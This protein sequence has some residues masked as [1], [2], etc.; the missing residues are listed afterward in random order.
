MAPQ[1]TL[2]YVFVAISLPPS[3]HFD[4]NSVYCDSHMEKWQ[5][6]LASSIVSPGELREYFDFDPAPLMEVVAKY[7][8]SI[9]RYYLGL[10]KEIGDPIWLQC[11]PDPLEIIDD[12]QPC[13]PLDEERLSP[14]PGLIHRYP[15]R[16][17]WLVSSV[18]AVYCRF[19]MRKRNIGCKDNHVSRDR[20]DQIIGYIR[21]NPQIRDVILSGGDPLLLPDDIL[22]GILRSLKSIPH[23][24]I[25]RI[26]TRLPVTLPE[27]I[28]PGLCRMLKGYHPLYVNTHFN[29]PFEITPESALACEMLADAGIPM[30]NQTVLLR[31]VNDNPSIMKRLMQMLLSIRVKPYYIHQMDLVTGTRHFRTRIENGRRIMEGLRG[32]T[33]GLAN[34][35]FVIDLQ[36]GKGKVSLDGGYIEKSENGYI[37]K[38]YL[39]ETVEYNE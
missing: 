33:S 34:P 31:G 24:E 9:T 20:W 39:N 16:V 19:C 7:P 27:R 30:G 10:I 17:V 22:D 3:I 1:R 5:K 36:G 26:G 23:V 12:M 8:M 6:S 35:H 29:H 18:C 11:V 28:T 25:I 2:V 15:D 37:I 4:C 21:E 13:D 38:N 32:Y 14:V